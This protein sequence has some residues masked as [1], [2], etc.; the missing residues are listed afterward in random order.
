MPG[1]SEKKEKSGCDLL[2]QERSFKNKVEREGFCGLRVA[3]LAWVSRK[4]HAQAREK[5]CQQILSA[6][7]GNTLFS[8]LWSVK[9]H[10]LWFLGIVSTRGKVFKIS[11]FGKAL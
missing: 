5:G 9:E 10:G 1:N 6:S 4:I 8:P 11:A 3:G 7:G 2:R